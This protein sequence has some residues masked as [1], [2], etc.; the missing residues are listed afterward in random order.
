MPCDTS[1]GVMH[2]NLLAVS[3]RLQCVFIIPRRY[4]TRCSKECGH[5][6]ITSVQTRTLSLAAL[7][8]VWLPGNVLLFLSE[9]KQH[10]VSSSVDFTT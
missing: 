1:E 8:S 3:V 6:R 9:T 2:R 10:I 4:G 7:M 5:K